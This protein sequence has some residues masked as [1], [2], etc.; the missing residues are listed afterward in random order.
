[1]TDEDVWSAIEADATLFEGLTTEESKEK[2]RQLSVRPNSCKD[3]RGWNGQGS[4]GRTH[5]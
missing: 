4:C 2:T 5:S 1:M 3:A